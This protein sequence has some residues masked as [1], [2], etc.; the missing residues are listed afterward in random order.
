VFLIDFGLTKHKTE[1]KPYD[2]Y[3]ENK[4]KVAG[5]AIYASI[6]A[7]KGTGCTKNV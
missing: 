7:H 3:R 2:L 5:T 4:N 1:N 6:N